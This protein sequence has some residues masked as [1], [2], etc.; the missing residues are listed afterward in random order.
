MLIYLA[1]LLLS[2][3]FSVK[4][5]PLVI[6]FCHRYGI[7]DIPDER[8]I[9]K[10]PIP[11]IGGIAVI[12]SILFTCLIISMV[13]LYF[14]PSFFRVK[15]FRYDFLQIVGI[16]FALLLI[17]VVGFWDDVFGVRAKVKLL[18][19]FL[20]AN[21]LYFTGSK[22]M[23]LSSIPVYGEVLSYI[24][25]V[26]WIIGL[27]NAINLIDGMDGALAGIACISSFTLGVLAVMQ[28]QTVLAVFIFSLCGSLLGFLIFNFNPAK[29]FLGDTGSLFVGMFMS[30]VSIL[31]YF[32]KATLVSLLVP[33]IIFA[34]PIFDT[35]WAIVRR[36]LKGRHIFE[37]DKEHI[38]HKLLQ[39]GLNQKQAALIL[40]AVTLFLSVV[41]FLMVR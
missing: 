13:I 34:I 30:I 32:K 35:V 16:M 12:A 19:Q 8:R 9:H 5:T 28:G 23:F 38:H 10:Q 24:V 33:I 31:G 7:V 40:Y 6:K 2:F 39:F 36:V 27:T 14:E 29:I 1:V 17:L 21:V 11:R 18:F 25:T 37:P 4:F 22:I 3:I 15:Y 26:L 41:A 20:A